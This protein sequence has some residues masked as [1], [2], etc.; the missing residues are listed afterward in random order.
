MAGRF[1]EYG[2]FLARTGRALLD[3][4]TW[5][6]VVLLQMARVGVDSL[7]IALF[8]A[9]FTGIVLALQASYTFTGAVPLYFV[10]VLVGKTMLLE[11]G[12]VLTGLA[13]AGR[14]GANIAAEL[15][16]M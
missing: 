2:R 16:T 10:G 6:R 12:P 7:P 1:G 9:A 11:L 4:G 3:T 14:V 8:I 15:G 13:L 5:T